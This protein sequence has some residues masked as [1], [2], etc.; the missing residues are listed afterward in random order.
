MAELLPEERDAIE[1]LSRLGLTVTPV[2]P[3]GTKTPEF[4]VDG[5]IRGYVV[6][7]KTRRDS[8]RWEQDLEAGKIA[9]Q[10]RATGHGRW[11]PD[12]AREAIK[13][14]KFPDPDHAR[15]WVL[16]LFIECRAS[17]ETM[18]EQAIGSLFGVRQVVDLRG[19]AGDQPMWDVLSARPGV[20]ERN[21]EIVAA[22]VSM[23]QFVTL[24]VNEL[25]GDF[26]A[27]QDSRLYHSF[28]RIHPPMTATVLRTER[29]F[30]CVADPTVD[31]KSDA[32]TARYLKA[33]YGLVNPIMVD[34]KEHSATVA[35]PDDGDARN[36]DDELA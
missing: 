13:Q 11:A 34:M 10:E 4:L 18:F 22:L 31:R 7:V 15:F 20:F 1:S 32:A 25:A 35:V 17:R 3:G 23:D 8:A 5:D 6:E 33:T 12:V 36:L 24:C 28:A 14:F 27:F 9:S 16:W 2:I 30:L 19:G 21:P 26:Q 29:G